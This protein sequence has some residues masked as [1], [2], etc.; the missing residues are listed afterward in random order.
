MNIKNEF[1]NDRY[2]NDWPLVTVNDDGIRPAGEPDECFYCNQKVGQPHDRDCVI[3][4][5]RVR[6]VYTVEAI[7]EVPHSLDA[8]Q[9]MAFEN[10]DGVWWST[11]EC[12]ASGYGNSELI[13]GSAAF[14][15]TE[16]D[17]P[18]RKLTVEQEAEAE[19]AP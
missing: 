19:P 14:I 3:I 18:Q 11:I 15:R 12:M 9:F 5:K 16:D 4:K 13:G 8:D 10:H 17:T 6:V 2:A 7:I 1:S